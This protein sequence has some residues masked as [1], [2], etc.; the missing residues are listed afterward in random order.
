MRITNIE[1]IEVSPTPQKANFLVDGKIKECTVIFDENLIPT[2][3]ATLFSFELREGMWIESDGVELYIAK[4]DH[5]S[6]GFVT[7]Y[8][9]PVDSHI[10]TSLFE[11]LEKHT[12][13]IK[14]AS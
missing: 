11:R 13:T 10:Y 6:E 14:T 7:V 1:T 8:F 4:V 12:V 5:Y 9:K 2:V 3:T